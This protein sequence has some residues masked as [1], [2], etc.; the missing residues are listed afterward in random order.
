MAEPTEKRDPG[1]QT[2]EEDEKTASPVS[3][4]IVE[5]SFGVNEKALLR[6]LDLRLLPPLTLLYLLSFLDRSNVGNARIE[7]MATDLKITGDQ[8]LNGLTLYFVGYVLFEVPCN[9][10]LKKTTPRLWLPTLTLVWGIISTLLGVV[11]NYSGYLSSRFFLGVAESGLFP[12]VVFYLSMWYKRNEQHYRVALFFC[13]ASL[14]GAFGG[15]LAWGI[16]HMRGVGGYN[17]WRWIF[18]LEG[19]LT[20][21]VSA[22]AYFWIYNY[23]ATAEF[24]SKEEREFIQFRLKNDNDAIRTEPFSWSAVVKAFKDPKVWLY[25]LAF[26]TMSLPL[27]TLSLF[28]PTIITE[29]G[30]S[31]AEAQLLSVPPYAV[32]FVLTI[33]VAILSER[34]R[35]RAPFIIGSSVLAIIG[36]IILLAQ[37]RAGV[38]YLGTIFAA[39]GIYPATAIV[40]S[41]PANNVSGQTK[42]A[43]ANAMQISIGNCGAVLGTQLYRTE[44]S[45]RFFLGHG[46]ALGYLVANTAVVSILWLVLHK[47]NQKKEAERERRGL[48]VLLGD[49]GDAEGEFQGDEDPRWVFQT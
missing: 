26:H 37:D 12:G 10:V 5:A 3:N 35:R 44:T 6:K 24:L 16:S 15:I 8:Y 47:E 22:T 4:S 31:A 23:P 45:P 27:Y 33:A 21:V 39:A 2:G 43:I 19:L 32:A 11:Q 17:G 14:A 42:R 25:G 1:V 49:I 36:Y 28:L 40:L 34:I 20:V 7:G 41:W 38:S 18:I 46:F 30:Y 13:A 48:G 29:L 9:I